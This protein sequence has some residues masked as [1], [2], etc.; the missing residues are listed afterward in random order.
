MGQLVLDDGTE[1]QKKY[2]NSPDVAHLGLALL[3]V[4]QPELFVS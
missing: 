2:R 4:R 1:Q 3:Q